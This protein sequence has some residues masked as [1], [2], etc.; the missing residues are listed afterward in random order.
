[1]Y[2]LSMSNSLSYILYRYVVWKMHIWYRNVYI[3]YRYIVL[4]MVPI[5]YVGGEW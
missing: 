1:M 4:Y 2:L 3:Y 5:V